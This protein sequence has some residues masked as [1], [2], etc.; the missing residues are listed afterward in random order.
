MYSTCDIGITLRN[1]QWY[2]KNCFDVPHGVPPHASPLFERWRFSAPCSATIFSTQYVRSGD[3]LALE[4]RGGTHDDLQRRSARR[5]QEHAIRSARPDLEHSAGLTRPSRTWYSPSAV[6]MD[7]GGGQGTPPVVSITAPA[8]GTSFACAT[9]VSIT[10][11]ASRCGR[12]RLQGGILRRRR[13]DWLIELGTL[14][15]LSWSGGSSGAHRL[16]AG[17]TDD[18]NATTT[19]ASVDISIGTCSGVPRHCRRAYWSATGTTSTTAP[20][21]SSCVMSRQPGRD[22]PGVRRARGRVHLAHRLHARHAHL[23]D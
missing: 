12:L 9:P 3:Q 16:T 14:L 19:S 23:D 17:A 13:A 21:S 8:S 5:L 10:A 7:R 18:S 6:A 1:S 15:P 20:A 22:Q 4:L 11:S 2:S